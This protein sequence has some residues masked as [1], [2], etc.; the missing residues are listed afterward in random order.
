[1]VHHPERRNVELKVE[2]SHQTEEKSIKGKR[3]PQNRRSIT[4]RTL[5]DGEGVT[6]KEPCTGDVVIH[7]SVEMEVEKRMIHHQRNSGS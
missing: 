2:Q 1:V 5:V 4:K 7:R 6:T 3:T